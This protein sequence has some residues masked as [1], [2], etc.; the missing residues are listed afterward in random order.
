MYGSQWPWVELY[1]TLHEY[2]GADAYADVLEQ[3]PEQNADECRWLAEFSRRTGGCWSAATDEDLC[4]LYAAFRVASTLLLR[5][6]VGRADGTDYPGPAISVEGYQRFH[7]S[8][9]FRVPQAA[10]FHPFFHEIVG[11]RQAAVA[12]TPIEIVEQAWPPLMLGSMMF[13]RAGTIVSGGAAHVVK[14]VAER[15][16][17]YWTFRRKDR[18]YADQS[19]GWGS[20]SQWRT[21]LRRD[22]RSPRGFHYNVDA[23]ESLDAATGS[24]DEI[25]VP[26]MIELVRNRCM[27]R[28]AVDDSDL[29][30]SSGRTLPC[31]LQWKTSSVSTSKST[32]HGSRRRSSRKC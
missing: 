6:Q 23:E 2:H 18:P 20:K 19:H 25:D 13:C 4:R 14:D 16:K 21:Q 24:V 22:Y 27:I 17:L 15:S 28:T 11:V 1:R 5:F 26:A 32:S 3:W 29:Y 12:E 30:P 31:R 8:L 10:G 9:G 7:E